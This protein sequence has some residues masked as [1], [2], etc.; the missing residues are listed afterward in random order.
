MRKIVFVSLFFLMTGHLR[1]EVSYWQ[2]EMPRCYVHNSEMQRRWAWHFLAQHIKNM[3]PEAKILDIGCGDGKV[4]AD[5]SQFVP[6]G[7]VIG[8]DPSEA[9]LSWAKRQYHP[10]EYPNLSFEKGEFLQIKTAH[11]FDWVVSFCAFHHCFDPKKALEE[12]S[13]VLKPQGKLLILVPTVRENKAW[14]ESRACIQSKPKWA[15]YWKDYP[16]RRYFSA[17]QYEKLLRETGFCAIKVDSVQTMDPFLDEK[18][19]LDWLEGTF[20]PLIPKDQVRQFYLEWMQEYIRLDPSAKKEE[21]TI[22]AKLGFLSLEAT[23]P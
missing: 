1:A 17:E 10:R 5:I 2:G 13:Q 23:K 7:E 9:M 18:E 3:A 21:G 14:N 12:I 20:P 6:Q 11:H 8:L 19:L 4:T 16:P 22:Y 15:C